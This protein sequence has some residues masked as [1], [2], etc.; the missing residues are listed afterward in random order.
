MPKRTNQRKRVTI[1]L[2]ELHQVPPLG[3][4]RYFYLA[5]CLSNCRTRECTKYCEIRTI[6]YGGQKE[7]YVCNW[8][9]DIIS[10]WAEKYYFDHTP[11]SFEKLWQNPLPSYLLYH[12]FRHTPEIPQGGWC[13]YKEEEAIKERKYQLLYLQ[14]SRRAEEAKRKWREATRN[15]SFTTEAKGK[16]KA[17]DTEET[18][19]AGSSG[20]R[21]L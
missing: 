1:N 6:P 21:R 13:Q 9:G 4:N 14:Y 11:N 19:S 10:K 15:F 3:P 16:G 20:K 12:Q 18:L 8:N 7:F 17:T 5:E 2:Q